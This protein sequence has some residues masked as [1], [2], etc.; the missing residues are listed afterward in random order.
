MVKKIGLLI[1][2]RKKK[3]KEFLK[4]L[5]SLLKEEGFTVYML[6]QEA[7]ITGY[8]SL[9][10]EKEVLSKEISLLITLG[11]DGTLL[12]GARMV[13]PYGKPVLGV[14]LGGLGFLT[15]TNFSSFPQVLKKLKEGS[16]QIEERTM[17]E[18]QLK[19]EGT[20]LVLNDVVVV[21]KDTARIIHLETFIDEHPLTDFMADGLIIS[22]PT[23]STAHSLSAGGPIIHPGVEGLLLVPIC[24]HTLSNRPLVI[25]SSSQIKI[26]PHTPKGVM[27]ILDGQEVFP[28]EGG[29]E[30]KVKAS[31]QRTKLIKLED[32][33]Y[34]ERLR[35]KLKW[36]GHS[37]GR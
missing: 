15:E 30:I 37:G 27:V 36:R 18:V 10:V 16:Y 35:K 7:E 23:G 3:A 33:S 4:E 21:R 29:G 31:S 25:P 14:N 28:L 20:H 9:G 6:P 1:N 26:I 17:L 8:D 5:I 32:S 22:T 24:P 2:T 13:S 34:Y 12:R 11:G 19:E